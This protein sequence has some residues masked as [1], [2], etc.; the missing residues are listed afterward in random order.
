MS[1]HNNS[2]DESQQAKQAE[3]PQPSEQQANSAEQPQPSE[4]QAQSA[5]QP[6]LS[7]QQAQ[8]AEQPQLS[9][10]MGVIYKITCTLNGKGYVGQT[11]QKLGRRITEHKRDSSK[12]RPGIDAAIH[13]YGWENFTVEVLE[14]CPIEFLNERE[15]FFISELGT[16]AP[17]GYNLTDGGDGGRGCPLSKESRDKI[18]AKLKGRPAHN[19]GVKA[20]PEACA[21]MSAAQKA[22]GNRP[23]NHKGKKRKPRS[24]ETKAKL[25]A[26]NKGKKHTA[27]TRAKM[28]A[29]QKARWAKKKLESKNKS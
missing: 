9:G 23:P 13:K 27:E 16:K 17:N 11:R 20:T 12:G 28:S 29:A 10:Q 14:E 5:E 8:S 15:I 7:E 3:Q 21:R 26:A 1:N 22:A 6:Q 2:I 4:Q 24:P 18:S 25:S 19:K